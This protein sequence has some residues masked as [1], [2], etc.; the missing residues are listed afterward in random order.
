MATES[1]PKTA[2]ATLFGLW[3]FLRMPFVLKKVAQTFQRLMDE[4]LKDLDFAFVYLDNILI[5]STSKVQHLEHLRRIF[6]LLSS[7]GLII[8]KS[9]C[10]FGVSELNYLGHTVTSNGIRPPTGRIQAIKEFPIPQ[11]RGELQRFLSMINYYH[12]FLPGIAPLHAASVGRGKNISWTPQCQ[13][14]FEEAKGALSDCTLL[15]HPRPDAKT[16]ITVDASDSAIGAQLKQL[17]RGRWVRINF[18]SRKLSATEKNYSA[19]DRE[20]LGSYEAIKHS[21]HFVEARPF[22][23]YTDHKPLTYMPCLVHLNVLHVKPDT[24]HILLNLPLISS[25]SAVN[26]TWSQMHCRVSRQ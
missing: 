16:S 3:E 2:I 13:K 18:F 11:T 7:N 4:I 21:R 12:R 8:N 10:V 23:L 17:Q 20:L 26:T 9:K 1:I 5:A 22:T 25:T 14:V 19:F 6:E 24:F 15:Y